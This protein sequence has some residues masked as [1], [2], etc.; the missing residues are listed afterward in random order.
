MPGEVSASDLI[1]RCRRGEAAARDELFARYRH[2]L[3]L[4]AQ[5]QS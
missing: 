5:A 4:L 2:Y 1:R 3:W